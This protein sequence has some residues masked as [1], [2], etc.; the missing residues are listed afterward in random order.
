[1]SS[2]ISFNESYINPFGFAA[3]ALYGNNLKELIYRYKL[4]GEPGKNFDYQS[5][6]T[7]LLCFILEKTTG[8][9]IY[10]YAS[11]KIWKNIG[12]QKNA[13]WCLDK[14]NGEAR[15]F[16]C[17]NSNAKD[18]SRLGQLMLHN[19]NYNGTQIIDTN[20]VKA[21]TK[22]AKIFSDNLP[23]NKYGYHWWLINYKGEEIFYAR[24]ILGQYIFCIPSKKIVAVRLGH[25]RSKEKINDHPA[26][27]YI[28]LEEALNLN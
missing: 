5:G 21:T 15:A 24:G 22:A 26:D 27:V 4:E 20:Y 8:M 16:C 13:L 10:T 14:K 1:M 25:K 19:G 7:Q 18:F 6:N 12:A 2:S 28:Y 23:N 17:F 11:N 3:E 9:N